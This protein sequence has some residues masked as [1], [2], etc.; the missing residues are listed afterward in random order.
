MT[1]SAIT[2][3]LNGKAASSHSH[4]QTDVSGL[5]DVLLRVDSSNTQYLGNSEIDTYSSNYAGSFNQVF[6][7]SNYFNNRNYGF[8]TCIS[9]MWMPSGSASGQLAINNNGA[10][11]SRF[12]IGGSWGDWKTAF[13]SLCTI[14]D[15]S[16]M[17]DYKYSGVYQ[18]GG[19]SYK[20]CPCHW[21]LMVVFNASNA[22]T[23]QLIID[24]EG[25]LSTRAYA[26]DKGWSPW[27]KHTTYQ[28]KAH[29]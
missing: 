15:G 25:M 4:N 12:Y 27:H 26:H 14:G 13:D 16:N 21:G 17:D 6:G 22:Y 2:S 5:N 18:L 28:T 8:W 9:N 7:H 10:I 24:A 19:D 20:N 3:A 1:Q 23:M 29:E 11:A